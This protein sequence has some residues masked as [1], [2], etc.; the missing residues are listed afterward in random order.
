MEGN[1][2]RIFTE[3]DE[4]RQAK[5]ACS[6][7]EMIQRNDPCVAA[8]RHETFWQAQVCPAL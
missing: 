4:G 7:I 6:L 5:N 2:L 8:C 3:K 1:D